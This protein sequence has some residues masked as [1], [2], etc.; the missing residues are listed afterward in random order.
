MLD[1]IEILKLLNNKEEEGIYLNN[2]IPSVNT[3]Y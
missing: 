2:V 1:F 3:K